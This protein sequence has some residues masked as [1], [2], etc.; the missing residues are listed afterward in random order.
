MTEWAFTKIVKHMRYIVLLFLLIACAGPK[1]F[2]QTKSSETVKATYSLCEAEFNKCNNTCTVELL[3]GRKI[4]MGSYVKVF[5]NNQLVTEGYILKHMDGSIY[6]LKNKKDVNDPS[7]CGGCCGTAYSIN[8][9][10]KQI[11]GC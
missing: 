6:I 7:I 4:Q 9:A 2:A 1:G 5:F 10:K 11:W 8:I 3:K